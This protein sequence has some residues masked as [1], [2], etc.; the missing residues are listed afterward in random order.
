MNPGIIGLVNQ[1]EFRKPDEWGTLRAWSWG[2]SKALDYLQ[3]EKSINPK[4]IGI[5]GHSCWGKT[6]ML[7]AAMDTRYAIVFS[8]CSGSGGASLEKRN[9]GENLGVIAGESEYHWMAPNF[10][11]YGGDWQALPVDAHDMMALIAPRP[12]FI[13]GG[14]QD[15]WADPLGEF[16]ACVAATP[17]YELLGKK[18]ISSLEI[19]SLDASLINSDLAFRLHEGGHTDATIG[20]FLLS[21]RRGILDRCR[22][23]VEIRGLLFKLV[24]TF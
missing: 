15:I 10:V 24:E 6:A 3:T 2:P 22:L 20:R 19:P 7:A 1:G 23:L 13:L 5:E 16:K 18:G 4:Q 9:F 12:L 17:V 14:T 11:K 8:S 21:L